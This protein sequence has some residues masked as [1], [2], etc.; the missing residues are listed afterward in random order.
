MALFVA[1]PAQ[2]K[3]GDKHVLEFAVHRL[4]DE[5]KI[6]VVAQQ[7]V[8]GSLVPGNEPIQ[9]SFDKTLEIQQN[10]YLYIWLSNES[11]TARVWFDLPAEAVGI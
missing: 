10:G 4:V 7:Y 11:K 5:I 8:F 6:E 2:F 3:Y 9:M 1:L